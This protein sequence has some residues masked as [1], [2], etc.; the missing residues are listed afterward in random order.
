MPPTPP[1]ADVYTGYVPP[2][3]AA[4]AREGEAVARDL[5]DRY[6]VR[7]F[8]ARGG[9]ASVWAVT[10]RTSGDELA[11]KRLDP[12]LGR[13]R[14]FYRELRAM[15]VVDHPNVVRIV[16]L[17]EAGGTRY[18]LLELCRGG[19]LRAAVSK[20]RRDGV[21]AT[22]AEAAGVA[23]QIARGLAAVHAR[24]FTHRDLKP[25]NVLF[26]APPGGRF[27]PAAVKLAD[28]GLTDL[29][30]AGDAVL[31]GLTG[32]PAYMAPEQFTDGVCRA[33]DVYS[34]GVIGLE[35]LTGDLPFAGSP[36]E[37]AA[38]HL[39]T[40]PPVPPGLPEP[41]AGLLPAML[42]KTP[43]GR[44]TA[45]E[46]ADRL[47]AADPPA[48]R[49]ERRVMN[50]NPTADEKAGLAREA[51]RAKAAL[52]DLAALA[53]RRGAA[54]R[55]ADP[56][57]APPPARPTAASADAFF[58]DFEEEA[59]RPPPP[60]AGPDDG[61]WFDDAGPAP[62][63]PS[64]PRPAAPAPPPRRPPVPPP[65]AAKPPLDLGDEAS[66][67]DLFPDGPGDQDT[68]RLPRN[69]GPHTPPEGSPAPPPATDPSAINDVLDSFNW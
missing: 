26:A 43:A 17:L 64:R 37:L 9:F 27:G 2:D 45:A 21:A 44:P 41:W 38:H 40:A 34:L 3:A 6:E 22:P 35:L 66:L 53:G 13:R 69:G 28:F 42:A 61:G 55:P 57:P 36:E 15:F 67:V 14:D 65:V 20:A 32:S 18:L 1:P 54:P 68:L 58:G 56:A 24:G 33:S 4:L 49:P 30:T 46:V 62:P 16:N 59:D 60:A 5:G 31:R 7:G 29:L 51:R 25:E 12:R 19:S 39:W 8:V 10:D 48:P 47:A 63:P 23:G 52:D 11:V 50:P